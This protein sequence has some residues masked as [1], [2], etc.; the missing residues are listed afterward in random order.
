MKIEIGPYIKDGDDG[1]RNVSVIID[2]YDV[3]NLDHTLALI[4]APALKKLKE[5][6]QGSPAVY[7]N[8]L[9]ENLRDEDVHAKWAWILDEMIFAFEVYSNS[10]WDVAEDNAAR[11]INGMRLF[12]KYFMNLWD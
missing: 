10:P 5:I 7:D 11:I 3:W 1:D 6:G 2:D 8:D 12:G 9:P 4:I